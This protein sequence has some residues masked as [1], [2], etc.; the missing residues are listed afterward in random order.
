[1]TNERENS[2]K[3]SFID[4]FNDIVCELVDSWD[5]DIGEIPDCL[6][7]LYPGGLIG[8]IRD[9]LDTGDWDKECE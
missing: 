4:K 5:G 6:E 1:M 7:E 2:I 3:Y 8:W 9:G